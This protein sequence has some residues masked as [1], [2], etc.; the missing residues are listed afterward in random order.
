MEALITDNNLSILN[1]CILTFEG[2]HA[3]LAIDISIC[4]PDLMPSII[5][6]LASS[7]G[8]SDNCPITM[9][10]MTRQRENSSE[11]DWNIRRSSG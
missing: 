4:S 10:C 6:R 5:W 3:E 9:F 1:D 8:D 11:A 2:Y 7:P